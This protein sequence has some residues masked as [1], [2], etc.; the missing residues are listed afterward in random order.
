LIDINLQYIEMSLLQTQ[1]TSEKHSCWHYIKA[2]NKYFQ[3]TKHNTKHYNAENINKN[4]QFFSYAR[5]QS[6]FTK[7]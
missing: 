4:K 3:T 6:Q 1:T 7:S 5:S 2:G